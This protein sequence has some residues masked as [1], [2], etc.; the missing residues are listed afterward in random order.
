MSGKE[1][2]PKPSVKLCEEDSILEY[3]GP[4]REIAWRIPIA[5]LVLMAEYSTDGGPWADDH[6][7]E[8]VCRESTY[9]TFATASSYAVG[10][11][12]VIAAL[13]QR[14][15][16]ILK[17]SLFSSTQWASRVMW[18]PTLAGVEYFEFRKLSANTVTEKLRQ[19]ALGPK[20]ESFLSQ[21]VQEFLLGTYNAKP[22]IGDLGV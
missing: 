13:A 2:R 10:T 19:L 22:S 9:F 20:S 3:R 1:I 12:E 5:G 7:L 11:D 18:P 4:G 14:W 8:F 16:T 21:P 15:K 6:F 17:P